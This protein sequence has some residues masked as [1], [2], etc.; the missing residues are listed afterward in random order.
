M[1]RK[2]QLG[3]VLIGT[4]VAMV[5]LAG[6][7]GLAI[8][9]GTLRYQKR[10]QQTAADGAAIAGAQ[11]LQFGSGVTIGARNASTQNG[12]TDNNSGAGCGGGAV[13]CI[14]IAVNNPPSSGPHSTGTDASK[15]V[16]V[17][18]TEVQPTYFMTIF[19]VNSKP[20]TARAV[21]TN[22]TGGTN[23]SCL[24]TL[25]PPTSAIVGIDPTGNAKIIAPN[26][27]ISDNGNLDTTGN[28][29]T[30]EAR[31]VAVSGECLGSHC[32]SPDVVCTSS[33]SGTCPPIGGAPASQDP[34]KGL[35][36]PSMPAYSTSCPAVPPAGPCDY[37]SGPNSTATIQPGTYNSISIGK[38]S[39][40]T[41]AP[42]IYYINGPISTKAGTSL[43]GLNMGG[44]GT[45]TDMANPGVMIYFTNGSTM[46]KF[47]GGGNSPDLR[48]DPM[49]TAENST[50]AGILMFQDPADTAQASIGGDN[51]TVLNG[52][53]YMPTAT[54]NF[55]GNTSFTMN[56]TVIAYSVTVTGNPTVTFG[57]SPSGVPIP[58][59]LTQPILVE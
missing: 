35:T 17:I 49:T 29:Y 15:Y 23:S 14:S 2:N 41:M 20:V 13:G 44:G 47:V 52:T 3:Q 50:Y 53:I 6:F 24:Y 26:C 42:G 7:A 48:L 30:V 45:L 21:A 32:G 39:T 16:E 18:V 43:A 57:Q 1:K 8:D 31:T 36:A 19:G 10:L 54:L 51:N 40:V 46:N 58:A 33:P 27:G 9:M 59:L 37:G 56:G 5:V 38:N 28:S 34:M 25:G 22:V 11:N 4:A 12:F 55:F